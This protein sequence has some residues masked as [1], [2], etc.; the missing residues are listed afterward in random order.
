[1]EVATLVNNHNQ[2]GNYNIVFDGSDLSSG[3][4]YY[5]LQA[6]DFTATKK[7]MMMK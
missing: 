2:A 6:G 7:L 1:M 4:Y 3:V 5:T